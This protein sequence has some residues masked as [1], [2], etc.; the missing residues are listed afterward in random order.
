MLY[1]L[2]PPRNPSP[3]SPWDSILYGSVRENDATRRENTNI[4]R[5]GKKPGKRLAKFTNAVRLKS[6]TTKF[7]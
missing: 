7:S 5:N 2:P 4:D 6:E 3:P 1:I